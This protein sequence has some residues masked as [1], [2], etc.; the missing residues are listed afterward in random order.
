MS[1]MHLVNIVNNISQ[2]PHMHKTARYSA[3]SVAN[4]DT[5]LQLRRIQS[6]KCS[7]KPGF[8]PQN[9]GAIRLKPANPSTPAQGKTAGFMI[10]D[11][12][13]KLFLTK[14]I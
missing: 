9:S 13:H 4:D 6:L 14:V 1:P 12:R 11:S 10:V 5:L 3:L 8:K 7:K 2:P